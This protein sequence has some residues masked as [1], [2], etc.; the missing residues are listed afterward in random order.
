MSASPAPGRA[1]L[2]LSPVP[3][4]GGSP[5]WCSAACGPSDWDLFF[6]GDEDETDPQRERR[7]AEAIVIC[8]RCPV[9]VPCLDEAL[10]HPAQHGV[11]GGLTEDE[12]KGLRHALLKRRQRAEAAA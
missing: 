7:E 9:R 4:R 11:A 5:W 2:P 12:R 6:G 8:H 1:A 3:A 10:S